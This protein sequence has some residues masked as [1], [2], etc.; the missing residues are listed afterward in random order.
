MLEGQIRNI[1][2]AAIALLASAPA[3]AQFTSGNLV[4][5]VEGNGV[6]GASS[7][8]YADNQAGPFTLF[9]Y[10]PSG[11]ASVLFINSLVFPQTASGA[12][13]PVSGEYGSSSEGTLHLSGNGAYL[14]VAGYG[15][16]AAVYNSN[17]LAY[18]SFT[19]ATNPK[20]EA[21]GQSSSLTGQP[22]QSWTAVP[23]VVVLVDANGN[24]NSS[25]A[26]YNVFN[27]NNPRSAFTANGTE[28]YV[29]GQG[30]SVTLDNTGG[31]FLAPGGGICY[32]DASTPCA[33]TSI[34]GADAGG[35]MSQETNDV[36]IVNNPLT[37]N[38]T[39]YVSNDSKEGGTNRDYV[40]TL[41]TPP[42]T[43]TY[44]GA[45][46]PTQL[47]GFANSN[48]KGSITITAANT[49]GLNS[50][51]QVVNVS[52]QNYFFASPS[53][54]Y[55]AD[56]GNP[57]NTSGSTSSLGNGGLQKW[58]NSQANGS[59]TWSLKY[60]LAAGLGLVANSSASGTT[61][62]YG[63]TG[64]VVS[65]T[66]PTVN[67]YATNYTILDLDPTFLY[68]I[69]D[70][71]SAT[72]NPGTMFTKLATA[73]ADSNFK[74]VSFAPV[75]PAGSVEITTAP[76]GL[77]FTVTGDSVACAPGSYSAPITLQWVPGDGTCLLSVA[78]PQVQSPQQ[79]LQTAS[80][81]IQYN[82]SHWDDNSTGTSRLVTPPATPTTY[83]ATFE[84]EVSGQVNVTRTG[85]VYSR[86]S[87]GYSGTV[88]ITNT[89]SAAV[90][91]PIQSVFTNLISGATLT[92]RTGIVSDGPYMGASYIT[93]EGTS[94]LAPGAA[95]SFPVKFT[96]SGTAPI[97]FTSKT[98]SGTL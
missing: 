51:G 11:T 27:T 20:A 95:V 19:L 93:V 88:T 10:A 49:N 5:A 71:L 39:L 1:G 82:F 41:G 45:S 89:G 75:P 91:F 61:G 35:G 64:Q 47:T 44:N 65:G 76:S 38:T 56:S 8:P 80:T 12:N 36:Q 14:T 69:T 77:A 9:Q 28:I 83:T 78:T 13:F 46:G 79:S 54:L 26:L 59:G 74:G 58:V 3:F 53:V 7:G 62:L 73:P 57:K 84:T 87:G 55:V 43:T 72:T 96:Y 68:G 37:S 94:P 21:L 34:T 52:P 15:I 67:L 30:N 31:V 6:A 60:T 22:G 23:R 63:L 32:F 92:N 50:S 25:S 70:T 85:F 17:P 24:V 48:G 98:I 29:S 90:A 40:G 2:I 4:V 97:S 86:A 16:N 81:G 33:I 66:T 42:S 18:T